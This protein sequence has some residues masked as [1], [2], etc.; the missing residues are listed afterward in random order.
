MRLGESRIAV[1]GAT[2]FL[3]RYIVDSLL[4][5]GAHVIGVVRNPT[6]VPELLN[7]G[8]ELRRADLTEPDRLARAF[9]GANA[10]VSNAALLSLGR[11][12]RADVQRVNVDGTRNVFEALA[13]AGVKR[14]VHVSSVAVYR[15]HRGT[16]VDE[17]YPLR[18]HARRIT[19]FNA[20]GSSKARSEQ[21]ALRLARELALKLTVIRPSAIYGAFDASGFTHWFKRLMSCPIAPYPV[22]MGRALVYAGDV[23]EAIALAL[24]KPV[25]AGRTY[26]IAGPNHSFWAFAR[27]WKRAGGR[28]PFLMLPLPLPS[29]LRYDNRRAREELGWEPRAYLEGCHD[30]LRRE[31]G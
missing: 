6:K 22:G 11:A 24:E 15:G 19:R 25:A 13:R 29:F 16:P 18:A 12:S 30:M 4:G 1:T 7:K 21:L 23:A 31:A 20:Y 9:A 3:G 28:T 26:N 14:A 10:V 17:D 5:R 8:V 2:G 27:E